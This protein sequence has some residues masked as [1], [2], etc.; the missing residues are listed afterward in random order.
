LYWARRSVFTV[1]IFRHSFTGLTYPVVDSISVSPANSGVRNPH[2][3]PSSLG[4]SIVV[5]KLPPLEPYK[6]CMDN[7]IIESSLIY[8]FSFFDRLFVHFE[9]QTDSLINFSSFFYIWL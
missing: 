4:F 8:N 9:Q 6:T 5:N 7:S 3:E 2:G 1:G